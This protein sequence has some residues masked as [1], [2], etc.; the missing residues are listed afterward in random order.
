MADNIKPTF[1]EIVDF[2]PLGAKTPITRPKTKEEPAAT[3][4]R[5]QQEIDSLQKLEPAVKQTIE[6]LLTTYELRRPEHTRIY[7]VKF[8]NSLGRKPH[9]G[10]G[11]MYEECRT[12][13]APATSFYIQVEPHTTD[14]YR[15]STIT[16]CENEE[17][18]C[19]LSKADLLKIVESIVCK[20]HPEREKHLECDRGSDLE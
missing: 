20:K 2:Q 16:G 12:Q 18:I 8:D 5:K 13:N 17:P 7:V 15:I 4:E 6:Q 14:K 9:L 1:A 19:A 10:I 11:L 3:A